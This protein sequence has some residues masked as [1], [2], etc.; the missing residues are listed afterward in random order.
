MHNQKLPPVVTGSENPLESFQ[1]EKGLDLKMS[2]GG[3][4][5]LTV[6]SSYLQQKSLVES[7]A[8]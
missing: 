4:H 7:S 8:S 6:L 5:Y 2:L 1:Q 3:S